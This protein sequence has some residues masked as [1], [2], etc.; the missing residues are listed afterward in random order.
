M[1][2]T[3][4]ALFRA[5]ARAMVI[6]VGSMKHPS[7]LTLLARRQ[8]SSAEINLRLLRLMSQAAAQTARNLH[9]PVQRDQPRRD[10]ATADCALRQPGRALFRF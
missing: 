9:Q 2:G 8:A 10:L 6:P 3:A 5:V 1:V 4:P 7:A